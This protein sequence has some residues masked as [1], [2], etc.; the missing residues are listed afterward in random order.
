MAEADVEAFVTVFRTVTTD[1]IAVVDIMAR[2]LGVADHCGCDADVISENTYILCDD[3][4]SE[5]V[6]GGA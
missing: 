4:I 6:D 1:G 3:K 2:G 5:D